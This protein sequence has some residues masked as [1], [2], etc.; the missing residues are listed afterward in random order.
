MK[1]LL[2]SLALILVGV[3]QQPA[4]AAE[5]LHTPDL[6]CRVAASI[7]PPDLEAR[8]EGITDVLAHALAWN[9][10]KRVRQLVWRGVDPEWVRGSQFYEAA[11]REAPNVELVKAAAAGDDVRVRAALKAG[12]N[13]NVTAEVDE[14]MSPLIWAATCDQLRTVHLLF[15]HGA[16]A[17]VAAN[18]YDTERNWAIIGHTALIAAAYYANLEVVDILLK[19]GANVNAQEYAIP[20]TTVENPKRRASDTPLLAAGGIRTAE[21]LLAH[22]ADP[23]ALKWDGT[24]ALMEVASLSER[25]WSKMLLEYG[26]LPKLRNIYGDTA[27]SMARRRFDNALADL[28]EGWDVGKPQSK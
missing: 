24:S 5:T 2:T 10:W 12:A 11:R 13:V 20:D 6:E 28:I 21:I 7:D 15:E 26:A 4:S 14:Y 17:N 19:R 23:N 9:D 18:A 22:G 1:R 3:T 25:Q 8:F 27:A 16:D